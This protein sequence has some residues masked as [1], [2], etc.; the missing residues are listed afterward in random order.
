MREHERPARTW[1]WALALI[2]G[3]AGPASENGR[4]P[5]SGTITFDGQ[6]LAAGMITFLPA[7]GPGPSVGGEIRDGSYAL[8]RRDGPGRGPYRVEITSMQPT[9]KKK[10]DPDEPGGMIDEARN[11]IPHRYNV[12]SEL[13]VEVKAGEDN[14]FNF[15]LSAKPDSK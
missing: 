11:I 4:E 3:C 2:A 13:K 15:D 7:G 9:G 14:Q 8:R 12:R 1:A 5:V 10:P 6:P